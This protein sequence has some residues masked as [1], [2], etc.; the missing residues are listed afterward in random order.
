MSDRI[1]TGDESH[2][3]SSMDRM[4]AHAAD[5]M[6]RLFGRML[7]AT[8]TS[9]GYDDERFIAWLQ[10]EHREG[11]DVDATTRRIAESVASRTRARV[12]AARTGAELVTAPLRVREGSVVGSITTVAE[13]AAAARCAPWVDSLAVAAGV[14]RELW[15]EPC[16]RWVEL[17][18]AV[19][20]G[21]YLALGV[22]GD[23]ML[24]HLHEGDVLVV[25][26]RRRVTRDVLVVA[27]RPDDGYVVKYVSRLTRGALELSSFNTAYEPF[28]I[29][30]VEGAIVGVVVARLRRS[31]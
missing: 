19:P 9:D 17:P 27:R 28:T 8:G 2:S 26:P 29:A 23:S 10:R 24:P 3:V 5:D 4:E 13:R 18:D 11:R 16:D 14:G 31:Y 6:E 25:D 15:D 7:D 21:R 20:P 12:R 22:A 30:R 1:D